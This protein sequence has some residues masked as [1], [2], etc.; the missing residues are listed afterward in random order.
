MPEL[1]DHRDFAVPGGDALDCTNFTR[2]GIKFEI[3]TVDVFCGYHAGQ[4]CDDDFARSC[5][6]YKKGK[7]TPFR[8]PLHEF[9]QRWNRTLETNAPAGLHEVFATYA[10]KFRIVT[11]QVSEL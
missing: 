8:T 9:D 11:N 6:Y 7:P 2:N 3:G 4:R 5:G 1:L 10:A